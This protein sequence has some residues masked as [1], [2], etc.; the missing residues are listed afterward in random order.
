MSDQYVVHYQTADGAVLSMALRTT[1][2]NAATC[3]A[4]G[5]LTV[6][7]VDIVYGIPSDSPTAAVLLTDPSIVETEVGPG[8]LMVDDPLDPTDTI[9]WTDDETADLVY[10]NE[11]DAATGLGT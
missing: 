1:S 10:K 4:D 8:Q 5:K 6:D 2:D 3:V 7:G 9:A 11:F